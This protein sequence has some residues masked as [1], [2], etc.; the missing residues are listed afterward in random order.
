MMKAE[1]GRRSVVA[2]ARP[3]GR[4]LDDICAKAKGVHEAG[5]CEKEEV[6]DD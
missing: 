4:E 3:F 5:F 1:T 6:I 2:E